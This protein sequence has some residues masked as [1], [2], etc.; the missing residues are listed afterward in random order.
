ML[1]LYKNYIASAQSL[2]NLAEIYKHYKV[3]QFRPSTIKYQQL[4]FLKKLENN[5]LNQNEFDILIGKY[6]EKVLNNENEIFK[7]ELPWVELKK[8]SADFQYVHLNDLC[9]SIYQAKSD[10]NEIISKNKL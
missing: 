6:K 3:V 8:Y 5:S 7:G 4:F 1:F 9:V 2:N 10:F